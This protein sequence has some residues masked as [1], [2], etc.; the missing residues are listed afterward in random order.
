[1]VTQTNHSN[2]DLQLIGLKERVAALTGCFAAAVLAVGGKTG[3][4]V[5][6]ALTLSVVLSVVPHNIG[7]PGFVRA[8]LKPSPLLASIL[9]YAAFAGFSA[10]W[11]QN[12]SAAMVSA[13]ECAVVALSGQVLAVGVARLPAAVAV[14]LSGWFLIGLLAG[15]ILLAEELRSNF[16]ILRW[17]LNTFSF[18]T[19]SH[20]TMLADHGGHWTV[21]D[22]AI[23]NWSIGAVN[24]LLWPSLLLVYALTADRV[25]TVLSILFFLFFAIVT[26]GSEH[27]T[28]QV[29]IVAGLTTFAAA[30][31]AA[32]WTR[33]AIL[34][35]SIALIMAMVPLAYGSARVLHLE[36]S[37]W[38][39]Y[40][41]KER[42]KI[43]GS[44]AEH[45]QKSPFVGIGAN[46]TTINETSANMPSTEQVDPAHPHHPHNMILQTWL[47]L[48]AI[49]AVLLVVIIV[50]AFRAMNRLNAI[51]VPFALATFVT[52]G[53]EA[54]ATWNL[55]SSW[56]LA[57]VALAICLLSLG[58]RLVT[59]A[60][61][62]RVVRFAQIWLPA[63]LAPKT[64]R[65]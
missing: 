33:H 61:G 57:A 41:L 64:Y 2:A 54:I 52:M 25:R 14:L 28:S 3:L 50:M 7:L 8:V 29:A 20:N 37:S 40:S 51:G 38:A 18:F 32:A 9:A 55:W 1:M 4:P 48:G 26:I 13:A 35:L 58:N 65:G 23:S 49:G 53:I 30:S 5:L 24:L 62:E 44:V 22:P 39:Q 42:F 59:G 27:Q 17:I 56:L 16:E 31:Y 10:L 46:N 47:E 19:P 45:I 6:E 43:W 36:Q 11:A 63:P 34:A 12:P 60:T 21:L 15:S